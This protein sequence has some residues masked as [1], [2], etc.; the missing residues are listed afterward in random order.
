MIV[1]I[2]DVGHG[3][4]GYIRDQLTGANLL[5]DC[6]YNEVSGVHPAERVLEEY[7]P[8][9]GLAIQNY[10]EDHVDG[11]P[12]L[13]G[14]TGPYPASVLFGN[15]T[16]TPEQILSLKT[17][18]YGT[19]ILALLRLKAL[20]NRP[21][22]GAGVPGEVSVSHY[23]NQFPW[24]K[25][26]NDLSLVTFVHGP[27]YSV[28]FTGDL[29]VA[30]WRRLLWNSAFRAELGRVKVFVASHHGRTSGYCAEAFD[31][32]R[33]EIVVISDGEI[34][35]ETQ[36]HC[37][38]RHASGIRWLWSQW[39]RSRQL[40]RRSQAGTTEKNDLRIS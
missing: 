22:A 25:N 27:A 37:Y 39:M 10:D 1:N 12:R 29:E 34:Q 32:C 24:V 18:P 17:P 5:I 28:V 20:Y 14:R 40:G 31:H 19:G 3:F 15:P 4:C 8:I 21:Y 26:T 16:V 35:Y 23:W 33:P 7:G 9:G 2:Y 11:L 36:A 6:G 30:G 38:A 13:L